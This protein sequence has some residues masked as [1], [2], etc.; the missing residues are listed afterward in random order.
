MPL[1][2]PAP[3][4]AIHQ[5]DI[6]CS[7]YRR[8]DGLWDIEG[9]LVDTKTYS[10][11]NA[12]RGEVRAGEPVHEMWLRLTIDEEM[13]IHDAEAAIDNGP[14]AIC[15]EISHRFRLLKGLR[16]GPGWSREVARR[17]GGIRG[18]THLVELIRPLATTAFQTLVAA[19]QKH[20]GKSGAAKP[21]WLNTCHAHASDSDVVLQRWP[22]FYTGA[23]D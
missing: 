1:P 10:F 12:F 5:R 13:T 21:R 16:I 6:R 4:E 23:R 15:P 14:Y 22:E 17:V 19:R 7:G 2:A 8:E 18:C 3:R 11:P 20:E 9:Y